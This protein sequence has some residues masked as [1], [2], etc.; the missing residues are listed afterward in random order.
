MVGYYTLKIAM[1]SWFSIA[2]AA[3]KNKRA[4]TIPVEQAFKYSWIPLQLLC[5]T[6]DLTAYNN[7][8]AQ[9]SITVA[10]LTQRDCNGNTALHLLARAFN[11]EDEAAA[12]M[13]DLLAIIKTS[14]VTSVKAVLN[15]TNNAGYTVVAEAQFYHSNKILALLPNA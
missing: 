10:E 1:S 6:A 5:F 11:D 13:T 7:Y 9:Y 14:R 4:N 12:I 3:V 8:R 15:M 2:A